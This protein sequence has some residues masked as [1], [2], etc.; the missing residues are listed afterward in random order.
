L[1][2]KIVTRKN[3]NLKKSS[4]GNEKK[5]KKKRKKGRLT[6]KIANHIRKTNTEIV[7]QIKKKKEKKFMP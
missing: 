2:K 4:Q 3:E 5:K 1:K 7:N 6:L